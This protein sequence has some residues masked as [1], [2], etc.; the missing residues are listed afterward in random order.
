VFGDDDPGAGEL[1]LRGAGVVPV[2][3]ESVGDAPE[4]P[5]DP[6]VVEVLDDQL[7]VVLDDPF[8]VVLDEP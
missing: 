2:D 7:V 4:V 3:D 1:A 5:V 8:V 6:L